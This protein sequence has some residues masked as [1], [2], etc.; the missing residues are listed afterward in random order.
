MGSWNKFAATF[1]I[2]GGMFALPYCAPTMAGDEPKAADA[3]TKIENDQLGLAMAQLLDDTKQLEFSK[4]AQSRYGLDKEGGERF[5]ICM[6]GLGGHPDYTAAK[7]KEALELC[8][9]SMTEAR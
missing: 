7:V 9:R 3:W 4:A 5:M 8:S 1:V 2:V 6:M